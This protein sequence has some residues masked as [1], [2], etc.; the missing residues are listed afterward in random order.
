MGRN[1]LTIAAA[2]GLA[3]MLVV[4][5]GESKQGETSSVTA[6]YLHEK[7]ADTGATRNSSVDTYVG[8]SLYK[9]I[10]G[11]ADLYHTYAF[12]EVST[13]SYETGSGEVVFDVYQF[14]DP[15]SAYGLYSMVRPDGIATVPLGVQGF[16]TSTTLDFVKGAFLVRFTAFEETP[17]LSDELL[18]LGRALAAAIPGTTEIPPAFSLFPA[19]HRVHTSEKIFAESFLGQQ[20]LSDVYSVEYVYDDDTLTLF[21][22]AD[23][24]HQKFTQWR[25]QITDTGAA[26]V[27]ASITFDAGL[28]FVSED[29]YYGRIIAGIKAGR[30]VGGVGVD[31]NGT[32][33]LSTWVDSL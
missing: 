13:A 3:L 1:A 20:P 22:T 9:Y 28:G 5:C 33:F 16:P 15:V 19:E 12:V 6:S 29:S 17:G 10:D 11:G 31:E 23:A 26:Q 25:D 30:L 4:G 27:P 14:A 8:D 7:T 21:L 2:L 24:S 18:R 32:E